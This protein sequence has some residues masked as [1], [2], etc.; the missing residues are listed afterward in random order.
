MPMYDLKEKKKQTNKQIKVLWT[1]NDFD[2]F[3][4]SDIFVFHIDILIP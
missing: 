2:M 1:L 3:L 4:L